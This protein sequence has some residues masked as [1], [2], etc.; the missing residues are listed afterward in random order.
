MK[1]ALACVVVVAALTLVACEREQRRFSESAG[2]APVQPTAGTTTVQPGGM[3]ATSSGTS[4]QPTMNR[5][6]SYENNAYAIS[7]GKRLFTWYNC[8]G[9]HARGGGGIGPPLMD[10]RWRYGHEPHAIFTTI[11]E[12][13]ANGM[14]A[15]GGRIPEQQVWQLVAYV[16][17]MSAL[18]PADAAPGRADAM[19]AG[20]PEQRRERRTPKQE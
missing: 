17:S 2:A 18:V 8:V 1:C 4:P 13:R 20:E 5:S 3:A 9:C 15:F 11:V 7:Q 6:G 19:Q 10:D 14:P 12:G 16:R